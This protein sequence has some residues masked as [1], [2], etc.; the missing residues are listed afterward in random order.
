MAATPLSTG[1]MRVKREVAMTQRS[2][3]MCIDLCC[4]RMN[5]GMAAV[6]IART[7]IADIRSGQ[8]GEAVALPCAIS[9]AAV[10]S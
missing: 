2:L 8:R 6:A 5:S 10:V 7:G 9:V 3:L 4:A 1:L